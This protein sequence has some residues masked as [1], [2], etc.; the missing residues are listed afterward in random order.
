ML[1]VDDQDE[2]RAHF[3]LILEQAN[4]PRVVEAETSA[5]ALELALRRRF[6]LLI[7]DIPHLGGMNGLAMLKHLRKERPD[8]Q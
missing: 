1:L 5:R 7:S 8:L 2:L 4:G 3:R 6:D